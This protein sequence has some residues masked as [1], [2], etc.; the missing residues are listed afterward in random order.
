MSHLKFYPRHYL[1]PHHDQNKKHPTTQKIT[2]QITALSVTTPPLLYFNGW[3]RPAW[4]PI[5]LLIQE[6]DTVVP[7]EGS[8]RAACLLNENTCL[9]GISMVSMVRGLKE[10]CVHVCVRETDCMKATMFFFTRVY[11]QYLHTWRCHAYIW[12]CARPFAHACL[13]VCACAFQPVWPKWLSHSAYWANVSFVSFTT[14]QFWMWIH[15]LALK[16]QWHNT[17]WRVLFIHQSGSLSGQRLH[18]TYCALHWHECLLDRFIH[19][20]FSPG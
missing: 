15:S 14:R 18:W 1:L 3:L 20:R 13:C 7:I 8:Q 9:L 17:F 10:L 19:L 2:F 16:S 12:V 6:L 11:L 5:I 4:C